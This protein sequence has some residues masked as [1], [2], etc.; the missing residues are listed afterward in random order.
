VQYLAASGFSPDEIVEAGLAV[1]TKKQEKT[2]Q[3]D[4]VSEK[5]SRNEDDA[6][7]EHDYSGLMDR[8]RSRLIIPI[9]EKSGQN[10][11]ALGGRYLEPAASDDAEESKDEGKSFTPA[12]YINSPD[13]LVFTKKN[14]L[15]NRQRSKRAIDDASS[16]AKDS[17]ENDSQSSTTSYDAP[18]AV[19]IVEGYFDAIAL[20][21]VGV[22]NVVASMGT[23]L[24]VEQLEI[25]AEMGNVPGG[26]IILCMDG[27]DAGR[28]AVERICSSNILSKVPEL[29]KNELYVA[30]IPGG[31]VKD[32][33]DFV[34]VAGGGDQA[35]EQFESEILDK[36]VPWDEWYIARILSK[37]DAN[38]NDGEDGSFSTICDEVSTFL[39]TFP[40]PAD[41][42]R[43]VH[44]IADMLVHLIANGDD[45]NSSSS[46]GML[47][48]Q[49][50]AD[51]L[52]MASRKA[53]VKEAME[54]RIEQSDGVSGDAAAS[55]MKRLASGN[56][57][58]A[59]EERKMS[60]K[61]LAKARPRSEVG[62]P[63]RI[64]AASKPS[65]ARRRSTR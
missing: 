30:T 44:K 24:P 6:G 64:A 31:D 41:R 16:K 13:S 19:V 12:K 42:T 51:I 33:S 50:E 46:I 3:K 53:G 4:K 37:H 14:V 20:S 54:R 9:M 38:A 26:R 65:N 22:R 55:K 47:R 62:A 63:K 32:P 40:S 36:A 35:R 1:R 10:A 61:A 52:N 56:D 29:N 48:V 59:D 60:R 15:F 18:P 2:Y 21:N 17:S 11:I 28:N 58:M 39:A 45:N 57:G 23:A 5:K 25:A 49:L 43:R 7:E 34:D 27:D 8:F